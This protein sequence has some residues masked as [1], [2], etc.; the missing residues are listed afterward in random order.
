LL[1]VDLLSVQNLMSSLE[2]VIIQGIN[3]RI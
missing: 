1:Q 2:K 3:F